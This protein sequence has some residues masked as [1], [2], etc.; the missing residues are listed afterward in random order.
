MRWPSGAATRGVALAEQNRVLVGDRL[1]GVDAWTFPNLFAA[2]R[3]HHLAMTPVYPVYRGWRQK[4]SASRQPVSGVDDKITDCPALVVEVQ[5]MHASDVTVGRV[6]RE[7]QEIVDA[8]QHHAS[9]HG[10]QRSR[11]VV[12][13]T[14]RANIGSKSPSWRPGSFRPGHCFTA[15]ITGVA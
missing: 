8:A 6:E 13:L 12:S 9:V 10:R 15:E 3:H 2:Q 1:V 5:I 11:V 4:D 7:P 14:Q